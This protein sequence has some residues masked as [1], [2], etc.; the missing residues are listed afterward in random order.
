MADHDMENPQSNADEAVNQL[1]ENEASQML[2]KNDKEVQRL[3]IKNAKLRLKLQVQR[4]VPR[5]AFVAR[6]KRQLQI[7]SLRRGRNIAKATGKP[8]TD[9]FAS[10]ALEAL[11]K[12]APTVSAFCS[13][14]QSAQAMVQFTEAREI[15]PSRTGDATLVKT[16]KDSS[17]IVENKGAVECVVQKLGKVQI[18]EMHHDIFWEKI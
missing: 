15:M 14:A 13:R 7:A 1:R 4:N 16:S 11:Y 2:T 17:R 12:M 5:R 10:P 8:R 3:R 9:E 6:P 18:G